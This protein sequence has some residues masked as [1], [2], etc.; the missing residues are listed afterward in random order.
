METKLQPTPLPTPEKGHPLNLSCGHCKT[1]CSF[2]GQPPACDE[3][4]W[5]YIPKGRGRIALEVDSIKDI[6]S[7]AGKELAPFR[8][9]TGVLLLVAGAILMIWVAIT[10]IHWFWDHPLW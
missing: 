1:I 3:C 6:V 4:G 7:I 8:W 5:V 9:L 10:A 2:S